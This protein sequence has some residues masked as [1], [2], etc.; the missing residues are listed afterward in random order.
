MPSDG[1]KLFSEIPLNN[2]TF[3]YN[4][5]NMLL[6]IYTDKRVDNLVL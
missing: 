1:F 5:N 3:E 2:P 4:R 6:M